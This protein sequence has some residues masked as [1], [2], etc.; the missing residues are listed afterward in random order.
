MLKNK[1]IIKILVLESTV[2]LSILLNCTLAN[3][4][5]HAISC[6]DIESIEV[7]IDSGIFDMVLIEE[8]M[9]DME[10]VTL[11]QHIQEFAP[12]LPIIFIAAQ[13]NSHAATG[14]ILLDVFAV[15][16]RPFRMHE[17]GMVLLGAKAKHTFGQPH[18]ISDSAQPSIQP[19]FSAAPSRQY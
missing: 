2:D 18:N 5:F 16:A 10:D 3:K 14:A 19:S 1:E 9:H 13:R 12:N 4:G 15:L 17:L 7:H 11:M 6:G 8:A